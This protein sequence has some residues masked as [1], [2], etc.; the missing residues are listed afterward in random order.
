MCTAAWRKLDK[1]GYQLVFNRDERWSR[2]CSLPPTYEKEHVIPG[3]CARDADAGGTW[4]FTNRSGLT[5]ALL[6]AYPNGDVSSR[7]EQTRGQLPLLA[8]ECQTVEAAMSILCTRPLAAYAPFRLLLLSL[9][10]C[11]LFFWDGCQFS[12]QKLSESGFLTS[13]SVR[14]QAVV[15]ARQARFEVLL[16]N[17]LD[18]TE[19]LSDTFAEDPSEA[20]Y[21]TRE[22][23]G[24]V[25][26]IKV[27]VTDQSIDF[28][29]TGRG[30]VSVHLKSNKACVDIS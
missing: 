24:T 7:G 19:C 1:H 28:I 22:D 20:L 3:F 10:E 11:R 18:L 26:Q 30:E 17:D 13:S 9:E 25:S 23:G 16:A 5:F 2:A 15:S 6:N 14:T 29:H 8:A 12:H 21:V 27:S 4:L